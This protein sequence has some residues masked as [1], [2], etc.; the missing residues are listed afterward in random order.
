[1]LNVQA[2]DKLPECSAANAIAHL[3]YAA[4][5]TLAPLRNIEFLNISQWRIVSGTRKT[6]KKNSEK[7]SEKAIKGGVCVWREREGLAKNCHKTSAAA[8]CSW[9]AGRPVSLVGRQAAALSTVCLAAS[10]AGGRTA[11]WALLDRVTRMGVANYKY[12][13]RGGR[14]L[15]VCAGTV[16]GMQVG[17]DCV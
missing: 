6:V 12:S 7:G 11:R 9:L 2:L 1:L 15:C 8:H 14:I 3:H 4:R 10:L 5:Q 17:A 16:C 13:Q